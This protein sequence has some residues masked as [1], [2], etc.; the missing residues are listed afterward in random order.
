[1]SYAQLVNRLIELAIERRR[2]T[3]SLESDYSEISGKP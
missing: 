3:D 1:V 2:Q